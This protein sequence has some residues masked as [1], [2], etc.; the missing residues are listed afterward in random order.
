LEFR[1][2]LFRST[3]SLPSALPD[4]RA[5]PLSEGPSSARRACPRC[6]VRGDTWRTLLR[7][8]EPRQPHCRADTC[9]HGVMRRVGHCRPMALA[10]T[11]SL[12]APPAVHISSAARIDAADGG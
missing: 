8:V 3:G 4:G 2:V 10:G 5:V 11:T 12:L 9:I 7:H 1:R 6:A